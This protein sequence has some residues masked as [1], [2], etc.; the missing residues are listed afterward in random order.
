MV[1][2]HQLTE[3]RPLR[4]PAVHAYPLTGARSIQDLQFVT[5]VQQCNCSTLPANSVACNLHRAQ[6]HHQAEIS[7]PTHPGNILILIW[8]SADHVNPKPV[9]CTSFNAKTQT[10]IQNCRTPCFAIAPCTMLGR[11]VLLMHCNLVA[12]TCCVPIMHLEHI[13]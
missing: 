8:L 4:L 1:I 5:R 12:S 6:L 2:C 11:F 3:G 7:S 13:L 10:V 9:L